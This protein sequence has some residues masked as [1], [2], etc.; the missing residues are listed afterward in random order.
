MG[1]RL[2]TLAHLEY[3]ILHIIKDHL[4]KECQKPQKILYNIEK[5]GGHSVPRKGKENWLA[6]SLIRC[7]YI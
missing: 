5:S 7:N 4:V 3:L 6:D 1:D 2:K